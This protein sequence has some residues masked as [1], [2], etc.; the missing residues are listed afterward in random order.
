MKELLAYLARSLVDDPSAVHVESFEEDD[1]TVVLELHVAADDAGKVIGR[2]GARRAPGARRRGRLTSVSAGR[3]GRPHG[4]DGSFWVDGATSELSEG[5]EV[6][7]DGR[8]ARVERRDGSEQRPLM[9][10]AGVTGRGAAAALR[11]ESLMV[12][13]ALAEDE[14]LARDLVGCAV[15]GLGQVA[16]VL[17]GPSC[18]LLEL[19]D[20]TLV[21]L[22]GDAVRRV[23]I[24]AGLIEVDREFLGG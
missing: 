13:A 1:G 7:V 10:L 17:E 18:D 2:G 11:G 9:R 12:E 16:R 15:K 22:V 21:P 6:V 23:D 20:G 8:R 19:E 5:D 24:D 3:V 4:R 14:W